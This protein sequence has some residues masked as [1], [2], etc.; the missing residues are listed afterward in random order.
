MTNSQKCYN[1]CHYLVGAELLLNSG[2]TVIVDKV[3]AVLNKEGVIEDFKYFCWYKNWD[4]PSL[5]PGIMVHRE[6]I[7]KDVSYLEGLSSNQREI[8]ERKLK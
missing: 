3:Y 5:N 2:I 8:Y 1:V 7:V 4:K 6:W